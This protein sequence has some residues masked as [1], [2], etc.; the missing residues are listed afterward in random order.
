ME[1]IL[2]EPH[3]D[4]WYNIRYGFFSIYVLLFFASI[5]IPINVFNWIYYGGIGSYYYSP[6]LTPTDGWLTTFGLNGKKEING[7]FIAQTFGFT[8]LKLVMED[9]DL[10]HMGCALFV[11]EI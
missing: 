7:S 5:Y 10:F 1:I 6:Y 11:Q 8:G 9:R 2:S 3:S 4:I